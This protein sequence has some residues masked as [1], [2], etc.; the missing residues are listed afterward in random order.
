[1]ANFLRYLGAAAPALNMSARTAL[2]IAREMREGPLRTA[3]SQQ[4]QALTQAHADTMRYELEQKKKEDAELDAPMEGSLLLEQFTAGWDE[5]KKNLGKQ[6]LIKHGIMT[7]DGVTTKRKM[8][9][10]QKQIL[11]SKQA[12]QWVQEAKR[13]AS[14]NKGKD[15][16]SKL[17][18]ATESGD[19]SKSNEA[20][21]AYNDWQQE[22]NL[23]LGNFEKMQDMRTGMELYQQ[24]K[25]MGIEIPD[26]AMVVISTAANTGEGVK[27]AIGLLKDLATKGRTQGAGRPFSVSGGVYDPETDEFKQPPWAEEDKGK[28]DKIVDWGYGQKKNLTT[29][30]IFKVPTAPKAGDKE[31]APW[32]I[33]KDVQSLRKELNALPDVAEYNKTRPRYM[34]MEK[35]LT[36]S[37]TAK[38]LVG[39]DQALI[40][41][42]NKMTDPQS[43]VRESEYART[44]QNMPLV[45][46][47]LGKWEQW[48]KGG[49]S[50]TDDEREALVAMAKEI[51]SSYHEN[52][53]NRVIEYRGYAKQQQLDPDQVATLP[54]GA[55]GAGTPQTKVMSE[56][57]ARAALKAKGITGDAQDKWIQ[58]YKNK[59]VVK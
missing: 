5:D 3:E 35:A 7:P 59:G 19:A 29:G 13:E 56:A 46:R 47:I 2:D 57:D 42:Y 28:E 16:F 11:M 44:P 45:N 33:G 58:E 51:N 14:L 6:M 25:S 40:N 30:E 27:E 31:R 39:V 41:L 8:Q 49:A 26:E 21:K 15:L 53:I 50:L 52:Y 48:T 32:Q 23:M 34:A 37:K 17:Q 12:S 43:V 20:K 36:M 55:G 4:R 1:M 38:N 9:D 24:V 54:K 18:K 22:H 10:A